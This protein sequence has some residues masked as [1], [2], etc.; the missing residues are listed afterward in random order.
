M[1]SFVFIVYTISFNS[2][3][4][5]AEIRREGV[6]CQVGS[7]DVTCTSNIL[8]KMRVM[9]DASGH[10]GV[11]YTLKSNK[12]GGVTTGFHEDLTTER[13]QILGKTVS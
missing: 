4:A 12:V 11:K 7:K 9:L 1:S 8:Q 5:P 10:H 2:G 13:V 3:T 6:A